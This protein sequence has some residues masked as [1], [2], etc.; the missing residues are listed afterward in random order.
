MGVH[1]TACLKKVA[2]LIRTTQRTCNETLESGQ[3][4]LLFGC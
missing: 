4:L 1:I 2:M 3:M